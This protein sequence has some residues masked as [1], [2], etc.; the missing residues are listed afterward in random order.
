[1]ALDIVPPEPVDGLASAPPAA[2]ASGKTTFSL[3]PQ[4]I[5]K[6]N[7]GRGRSFGMLSVVAW[8]EIR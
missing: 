6:R 2:P 7:T 4:A 5:A 8:L 1:M 3:P